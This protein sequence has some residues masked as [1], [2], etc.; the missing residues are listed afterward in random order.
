MF[1]TVTLFYV[2]L[3]LNLFQSYCLVHLYGM[4][5]VNHRPFA[6]FIIIK[7]KK[8]LMN[9]DSADENDNVGLIRLNVAVTRWSRSTQYIEPG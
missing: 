6:V 5:V 4:L 8:F 1:L 7:L 2:I 9:F 3:C